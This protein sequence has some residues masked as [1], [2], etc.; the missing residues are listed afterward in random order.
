MESGVISMVFVKL[1]YFVF[2]KV[3]FLGVF[4]KHIYLC[5]FNIRNDYLVV[6]FLPSEL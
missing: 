1:T 4:T 3:F 5:Y 6:P 2:Y